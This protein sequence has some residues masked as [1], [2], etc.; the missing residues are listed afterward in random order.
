MKRDVDNKGHPNHTPQEDKN[1][2]QI[3]TY[4][5]TQRQTLTQMLQTDTHSVKC[6]K[7]WYAS[8]YL[9]LLGI[10]TSVNLAD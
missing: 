1:S 5:V 8:D 2:N 6:V 10:S 4:G 3:L 9:Q 7:I